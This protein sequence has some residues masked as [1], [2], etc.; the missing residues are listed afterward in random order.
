M[1]QKFKRNKEDFTC[2]KC[3]YFVIGTGYTNHCPKCLWCKHVDIFPGDRS[4]DCGGMM[5]PIRLENKKGNFVIVHKCKK[6]GEEKINKTSKGDDFS[7]SYLLYYT[8]ETS[9]RKNRK[10]Y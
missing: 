6:C 8:N 9:Q 10:N 3:G 7:G 5:I 1:S 4:N 2:E